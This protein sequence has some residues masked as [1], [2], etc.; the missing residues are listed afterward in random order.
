MGGTEMEGAMA[1]ED[2]DGNLI[3][4]N[5][6]EMGEELVAVVS[7]RNPVEASELMSFCRDNLS[8]YKCPRRIIFSEDVGRNAMG[9][10]NKKTL[11]GRFVTA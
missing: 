7:L 6:D 8:H 9:K 1:Y 3:M 10:V 4:Y 5:H 11:R 2:E